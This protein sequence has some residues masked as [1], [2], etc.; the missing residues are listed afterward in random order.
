MV[1]RTVIRRTPV[2][3]WSFSMIQRRLKEIEPFE[4]GADVLVVV[5][6]VPSGA[7]LVVE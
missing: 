2:T 7:W 1:T 5:V 4:E 6:T 3:G